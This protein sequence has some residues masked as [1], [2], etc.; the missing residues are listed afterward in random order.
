MNTWRTRRRLRPKN[1][2]SLHVSGARVG[3]SVL[4]VGPTGPLL[5]VLP[6]THQVDLQ[7]LERAL[8]GP[9]RLATNREMSE[10]FGDCEWGVAPPFGRLYGLETLL[11][12]SISP[13]VWLAFKTHS[14]ME[15]VRIR[16]GDYERLEQPRRLRIIRGGNEYA[17]RR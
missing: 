1:G 13:D 12:E 5:A 11:E 2:P 15:A 3:K 14:H 9:V 16:C 4:L 17:P 6:A 7:G 8:G 10:V